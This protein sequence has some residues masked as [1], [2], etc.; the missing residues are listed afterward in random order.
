LD[1]QTIDVVFKGATGED[2][3]SI[4]SVVNYYQAGDSNVAPPTGSWTTTVPA[5]NSTN[6]YLWNYE[7]INYTSGSPTNTPAAVIGTY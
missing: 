2:G 4:S 3:V 1:T 7:T 6:K 5:L